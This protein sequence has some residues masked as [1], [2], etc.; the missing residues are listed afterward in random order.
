M[1]GSPLILGN[2]LTSAEFDEMAR[3]AEI[4]SYRQIFLGVSW[5]DG[6][7]DSY[8]GFDKF[9]LNLENL[10]SIRAALQSP[11]LSR[12]NPL[13]I[14]QPDDLQ[15]LREKI[16][17][18]FGEAAWPVENPLGPDHVLIVKKLADDSLRRAFKL[19]SE[20]LPELVK[21]EFEEQ[22]AAQALKA[23]QDD[24][25]VGGFNRI[26]ATFADVISRDYKNLQKAV[27]QFYQLET[28]DELDF[29]VS[30]FKAGP[31]KLEFISS[32]GGTA[33]TLN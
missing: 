10:Y 3:R 9:P 30:E 4:L 22:D 28:Q 20:G 13:E 6:T 14:I 15:A 24:L 29:A 11:A 8:H 7:V 16:I 23:V 27:I 18:S 1:T 26:S 5:A 32:M 17:T 21:W 31:R 19:V 12:P 33:R 2:I 25:R